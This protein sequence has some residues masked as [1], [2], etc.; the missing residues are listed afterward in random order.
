MQQ[1]TGG[2][3]LSLAR[4]RWALSEAKPEGDGERLGAA[5]DLVQA[6]YLGGE[7]AEALALGRA[8]L[9][10]ARRV[11][12]GEHEGT[13]DAMSRLAVVLGDTD[14]RA[15]ALRL[16]TEAL[17]VNRRLHGGADPR[18]LAALNNLAGTYA[19]MG[20]HA[21]ALL[22]L[23]EALRGRRRALGDD[24]PATLNTRVR[25]RAR[26]RCPRA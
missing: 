19:D 12:G 26:A 20:N 3:K 4:A 14:D 11:L 15:A 5:L 18:T 24:A 10:T 22:L 8:A 7:L 17:E 1:W 2:L 9:A 23:G 21:A 6:L 13:L 25:A 16:E